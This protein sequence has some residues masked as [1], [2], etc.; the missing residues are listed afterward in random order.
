MYGIATSSRRS[1]RAAFS[2]A[3]LSSARRA[4]DHAAGQGETAGD[5]IV[6]G[7]AIAVVKRVVAGSLRRFDVVVPAAATSAP[8]DPAVA[9]AHLD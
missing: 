3:A 4:L 9:T 6:P 5:A 7:D 2:L 8:V 1:L